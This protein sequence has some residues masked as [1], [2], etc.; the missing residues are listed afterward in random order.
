MEA[1]CTFGVA[2]VNGY[3]RSIS[4]GAGLWIGYG[5][6]NRDLPIRRIYDDNFE[7]RFADSTAN[8]YIFAAVLLSAGLEGRQKAELLT[9]K[10]CL[11]LLNP[12]SQRLDAYRIVEQCLNHYGKQ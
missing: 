7:F 4:D 11:L 1:L 10:D 6:E 9:W 5:T 12:D 8:M 2:S 3:V